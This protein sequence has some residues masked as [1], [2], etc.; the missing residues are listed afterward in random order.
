MKQT[1]SPRGLVA[2]PMVALLA[3]AAGAPV[4]AQQ[5]AAA[6]AD[7]AVLEEIVV[8]ARK[9][10][11]Q[12]LDVP[13]AITAF[14]AESIQARGIANLDDVAAFTP[15][16]T[17]SNVLGEFLPAPVIRGVAPI[18]IFGELN[19][20]I[21][22]DGVYVAGR[23]GINFNQLDLERIEVVKGPQ[24]ALYGRN[25]FSGAINYVTARPSNKA[26]GKATVT[27]GNDG[28]RL[29]ALT[30][31]GPLTAAGLSGRLSVTQDEW[32][33]SYENQYRGS[34]RRED[35]GGYR[36]RTLNGSLTWA[37]SDTFEAQLGLYI[38]DDRIASAAANSVAANCEDRRV[39]DLN[40]G[41][42]APRSSR[43]LNYCGELPS[44]DQ[45]SLQ[46]ESGATGEK[47]HVSR[48]NLKLHWDLDGGA[49]LD[50]IS[51]YSRVTQ[52]YVVDGNRSSSLPL[53]YTYQPTP[54][55]TIPGLGLVTGP[56][57]QFS[58][59]LLQLG[60]GVEVQEVSQEI[61][62]ASDREAAL[63]YTVGA[64]YYDRE[65]TEGVQGVV[66]TAALPADF[67]SF[68]LACT[69]L[70]PTTVRDF[71]AGAGNAAFLPY[72]T[73]P[74]G[75]GRGDDVFF[76]NADAP[77]V[78]AAIEY[79]FTDKFT[80]SV[81]ARYTEENRS[82]KDIR[83]NA[84]GDETWELL[85]WRGTLRFKPVDNVTTYLAVAHSEKSGDFDPTTVRLLS[86]PTVDVTLPGAFDAETLMSY[87]FGVKS[88]YF[89]R[90]LGI[91]LDIYHLEWSDIV[92]P[93]V[94]SN[95]GGQDIVTPTGINVNA[96]DA[97]IDGLEFSVVAR[98]LRGLDL[99]LGVSY[100]DPKYDKARVDSFIDFPTYAPTGDISGNQILRTSKV[101]ASAG[102]QFSQA[103]TADRDWFFRADLAHRGKQFAD[104][105]N[106]T[107]V[108]SATS[109]NASMGLRADTWSLELW[110]R[111]LTGED[112]PTGAF[113]DVF[114]SNTLPNGTIS[115]GTFF[116]FRYTVS[117]PRLTTWGLTMRYTF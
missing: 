55:R 114:F 49:T 67:Y 56:T 68:C 50:A 41:V 87:E 72:F 52:G 78:F 12:L 75:G 102:F 3:V 22:L 88:E 16:L 63:R 47:R 96:G 105:S 15:G 21:F 13:L 85:S 111:N 30:V 79:D 1:R 61:R 83:T 69:A 46:V 98:P 44:V 35:I 58:T 32:D 8:T 86:A 101:Q 59:G 9:T 77:A 17:F 39:R 20:A 43:L 71:A 66:A 48:G 115:G 33:G 38:S 29:A 28:K 99:N 92:I 74:R 113:R 4:L 11:E 100:A 37:A 31:S 73:D 80:G 116:P 27:V 104:A 91:E 53:I 23:E 26:S 14:T 2:A 10:S 45:D 97:S 106:Q 117:H 19:T 18:D 54:T 109:V 103:V 95:I 6:E 76:E 110:G 7:V 81:D 36:Y 70:G 42:A 60:G 25:A 5:T 90:R 82:F 65:S 51:G 89:D 34:A 107:I 84:Q 112:A 57:K 24:A 108:P 93:Q 62:Y 64:Y 94:V 40:L